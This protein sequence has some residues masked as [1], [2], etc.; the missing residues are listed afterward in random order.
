MKNI[1]LADADST[2]PNLALMKLSKYHKKKGDNVEFIKGNLPF[3]PNRNKKFFAIPFGY[4]KIYCSIIFEGNMENTTCLQDGVEYGGTG[5]DLKTK[6][7]EEIEN[8]DCDYSL[9]PEN[10][11][12]YGFITRGCIRN[13]SFCKVPE[14]EGSIK[15]VNDI[16]KI[17]KHNK[18]KFMDNNILA[19]DRH[20][21]ILQELIDKKIKCQFNQ[22]LD[23]RLIDEKNSDLLSR[24][25]YYGPYLFAFDDI[26][27]KHVIQKKLNLMQWRRAWNFKF[28]V[29]VHP[30]M[31]I[32]DTVLRIEWLKKREIFPYIMRDME[33]FSS[34]KKDFYTDIAIHCNWPP[35]FRAMSFEEYVKYA[36]NEKKRINKSI[37]LYNE[38]LYEHNI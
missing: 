5:Y 9:Y 4:D 32:R 33:C 11:E 20:Y 6:L 2:I 10:E 15:K 25:N 38:A 12:S 35:Y 24:M 29:Y 34:E 14:K 3:Y 17:V 23:V 31:K 13:C 8:M 28:F 21:E 22:G 27:I 1:L 19:Y 26:K 7:P 30:D 36:N 16:S 37:Q 18:V